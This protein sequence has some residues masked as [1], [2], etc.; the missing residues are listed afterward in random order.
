MSL[1]YS[2]VSSV[3]TRS[4]IIILQQNIFLQ[5]DQIQLESKENTYPV[6]ISCLWIPLAKFQN[7][8]VNIVDSTLKKVIQVR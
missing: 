1:K 6:K 4:I 2:L 7:L 3:L 8:E 5:L